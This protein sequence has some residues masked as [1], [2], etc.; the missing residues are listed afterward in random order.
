MKRLLVILM[1]TLLAA[2]PS[3]AQT[4]TTGFPNI[5]RPEPPGTLLSHPDNNDS[6]AIGRTTTLNYL[7]GWLIVGGESPGSRPGSDLEMRVYDI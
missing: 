2:T 6:E 5:Q 4:T 7:N 3:Q 1:L